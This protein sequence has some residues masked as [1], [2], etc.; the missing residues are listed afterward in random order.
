MKKRRIATT[1]PTIWWRAIPILALAAVVAIPVYIYAQDRLNTE[2]SVAD[3]RNEAQAVL[4]DIDN[5]D[6]ASLGRRIGD[7]YAPGPRE[8]LKACSVITHGRTIDVKP[9][10]RDFPPPGFFITVKSPGTGATICKFR[11]IRHDGYWTTAYP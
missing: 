3:A 8:L 4:T 10:S 2:P 1:D 5:K 7:D 9:G 11:L 6:V